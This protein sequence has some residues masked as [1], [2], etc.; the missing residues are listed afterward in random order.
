MS[1]NGT[2]KVIERISTGV[3]RLDLLLKGGLFQG[4]LYVIQGSPGMGK[5]ILANQICFEQ[6]KRGKQA[7]YLSLL[8]ESAGRMVAYLSSLTFVNLE[9]VGKSV[10]YVSGYRV[11]KESDL[12]GLRDLL[13]ATIRE[14]SA[15]VLV[16][17]GTDSL[18]QK[19]HSESEFREFLHFLQTYGPLV[20]CTIL[21]LKP[22][23]PGGAIH[24]YPEHV[25][26]DGL[27]ELS[28]RQ[29]GPRAVR[30]IQ[31]LKLRGSD[32]LKGR[33][34]IEISQEGVIVH[35][36]TE[37]LF[38]QTSPKDFSEQRSRMAFG[39]TQLDKMLKGGLLSGSLTTIIGAPGTGKT[40]LGISFLNAGAQIGEPGIYF[41]FHESPSRLFAKAANLGL[42]LKT[43]A[44]RD[45][46]A[47]QWQKPVENI[48]DSL[49][50][51]ILEMVR[52][53]K[54]KKVRVFIDGMNGFKQSL[55]YTERL[56]SFLPAIANE[57]RTLGATTILSEETDLF[58]ANVV[59]GNREL[60]STVDNIIYLRYVEIQ[61][62]LHRL[63]SIMKVR[64]SDYDSCLREFVMSSRGVEVA[65]SF[66]SAEDILSGY[67]RIVSPHPKNMK[68]GKQSA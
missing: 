56:A 22:A 61:S 42:E 46:I 48:T 51:S 12:D 36:R 35:P 66:H 44:D 33:H 17:D 14:H 6:A 26:S 38:G 52:E 30:E 57:L 31:V 64:D 60:A 37:V 9:Q 19:A 5:T 53:R 65:D 24:L 7:V 13:K 1:Q 3:R 49:A 47:L 41:G 4:G 23:V 8:A 54:V 32:F 27:I 63:I 10:H 29:F 59:P 15:R 45:L 62:Q 11:L 55:P 25:V 34:E 67:G 58:S 16:I 50:E 39:I 40:T 2:H 43:Y 28:E 18:E 68:R 21:L 20:N